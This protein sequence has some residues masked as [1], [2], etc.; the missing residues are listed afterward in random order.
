MTWLLLLFLAF[1]G[2]KYLGRTKI[3]AILLVS[4]QSLDRMLKVLGP[5]GLATGGH[6]AAPSYT[7]RGRHHRS[8][9]ALLHPEPDTTQDPACRVQ[10]RHQQQVG[11]GSENKACLLTWGRGRVSYGRAQDSGELPQMSEP[12]PGDG[13]VSVGPQSQW[14]ARL[15]QLP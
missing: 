2:S 13:S 3:K 7:Y 4:L 14:T 1:K 15:L 9:A 10:T 11:I 8:T 5:K 6:R 12:R